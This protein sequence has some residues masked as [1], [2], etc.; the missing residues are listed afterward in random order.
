[1]ISR[2]TIRA[3]HE[4]LGLPTDKATIDQV[5]NDIMDET[6]ERIEVHETRIINQ[7]IADHPE[8]NYVV[9]GEVS[10]TAA[11]A[12]HRRAEEEILEERFNAP[13][14]DKRAQQVAAG[15]DGW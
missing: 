12:A 6:I 10:A 14:R 2:V 3:A 8:A 5:A 13:I 7:W 1:M 9:P 11:A 4:E 15:E